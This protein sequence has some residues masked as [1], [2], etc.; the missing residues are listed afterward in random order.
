M[1]FYKDKEYFSNTK[2]VGKKPFLKETLIPKMTKQNHYGNKVSYSSVAYEVGKSSRLRIGTGYRCHRIYK[3]GVTYRI[4]SFYGGI[5]CCNV[6]EFFLVTT[7][8]D[9]VVNYGIY[10]NKSLINRPEYK[11]LYKEIQNELEPSYVK[12][13]YTDREVLE[14][15][16]Y[17][18]NFVSTP[19]IKKPLHSVLLKHFLEEHRKNI[20]LSLTS[21]ETTIELPS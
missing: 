5:Y 9:G 18:N 8:I 20:V 11:R 10:Y 3:N 19:D 13:I 7:S 15:I 14:N 1:I 16:V 6:N 2:K 21:S 4:L 12:V 17:P